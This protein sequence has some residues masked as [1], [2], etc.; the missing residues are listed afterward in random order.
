MVLI[1]LLIVYFL[2]CLFVICGLLVFVGCL[3][4]RMLWL[5][6][7]VDLMVGIVLVVGVGRNVICV[8]LSCCGC[9][10]LLVFACLL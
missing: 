1:V 8:V 6:V 4:V 9:C 3:F 7:W 2:V 10:W 5:L